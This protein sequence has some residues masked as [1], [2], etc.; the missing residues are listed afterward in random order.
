MGPY[1]GR[2]WCVQNWLA[3][4]P[5]WAKPGGSQCAG[6]AKPHWK[7]CLTQWLLP[8]CQWLANVRA[9]C[10]RIGGRQRNIVLGQ[11]HIRRKSP[12]C[13]NIERGIVYR[14]AWW[15]WAC[16]CP[17]GLSVMRTRLWTNPKV[18]GHIYNS[19]LCDNLV[20][21]HLVVGGV[22]GGV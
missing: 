10:R 14:Y 6:N 11:Q 1:L 19:F 9:L 4:F 17:K 7:A 8:D 3:V 5:L 16:K 18:R 12:G 15:V 21:G 13:C 2:R 22:R 20:L